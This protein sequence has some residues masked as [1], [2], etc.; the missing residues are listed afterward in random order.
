MKNIADYSLS[1][2]K[3]SF[4]MSLERFDWRQPVLLVECLGLHRNFF[5]KAAGLFGT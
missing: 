3:N 5:E 1:L 4:P 2:S